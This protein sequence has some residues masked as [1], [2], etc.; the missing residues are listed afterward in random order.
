MNYLLLYPIAMS[1]TELLS[2]FLPHLVEVQI[3][4]YTIKHSHIHWNGSVPTSIN[5]RLTESA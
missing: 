4:Q 5:A 2:K 1:V 3:D